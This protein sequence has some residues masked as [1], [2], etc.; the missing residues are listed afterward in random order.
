LQ[1]DCKASA[2]Y[3]FLRRSY[4]HTALGCVL[5]FLLYSI[6][7]KFSSEPLCTVLRFDFCR[8]QHYSCNHSP[9]PR[10]PLT[11]APS[12]QIVWKDSNFRGMGETLEFVVARKEGTEKAA[13]PASDDDMTLLAPTFRMKVSEN[14][15]SRPCFSSLFP[16]FLSNRSTNILKYIRNRFAIA[17]SQLS[18]RSA[19]A[20]KFLCNAL[21]SL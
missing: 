20:L 4:M 13:T 7:S 19:I 12:P 11:I 17:L 10:N 16:L 2:I 14:S 21:R 6:L 8:V 5:L 18:N 15:C 3:A 1:S 9:L